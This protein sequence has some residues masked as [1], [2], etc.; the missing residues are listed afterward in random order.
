MIK[1]VEKSLLN[2]QASTNQSINQSIKLAIHS[3]LHE[4]KPEHHGGHELLISLVTHAVWR[5]V[6]QTVLNTK[7]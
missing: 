5:C 7:Q 3:A 1:A 6:T 2:I 4:L